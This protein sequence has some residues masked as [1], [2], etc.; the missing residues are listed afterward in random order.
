MLRKPT[1][2][3]KGLLR[4]RGF[5][6]KDYLVVRATYATVWFKHKRTGRIKIVDKNN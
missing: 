6:W 5:D 4:R 1:E 2:N 3:E